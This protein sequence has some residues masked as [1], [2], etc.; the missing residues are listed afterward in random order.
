MYLE[1][2]EVENVR[3]IQTA[4]ISLTPRFNLFIGPNGSGKTSCLE[5]A[6]LLSTGKSFRSPRAR[7][8]ITHGSD[9]LRAGT[10]VCG[11][12]GRR[13]RIGVERSGSALRARVDGQE[14]RTAARLARELLVVVVEPD[15]QRLLTDGAEIRRRLLD[16]VMFHV[17]RDYSQ[18]HTR[19]RRA[20]KQRNAMLRNESPVDSAAW[21]T[22]VAEAG[23]AVA[24]IRDQHVPR[25]LEALSSIISE[26]V[27]R[28]I[29]LRF[30]HGFDTQTGLRAAL[31][32]AWSRDRSLGYT[33]SGPH[34]CDLRLETAG[35]SAHSVLS[36]GEGKL[37]AASLVVAQGLY[38]KARTGLTPV[39]LVDDLGAELDPRSRGR[40]FGALRD[41]QCQVL[42]TSV[43]PELLLEADPDHAK[44]FHVERGRVE[45]V[46]K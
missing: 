14:V 30:E 27:E 38:V 18:L 37:A 43:T 41:A 40:L 45:E 44:S 28:P 3:I 22:E 46:L 5:A 8:V 34:R 39:I 36:R 25:V 24:A 12:E 26:L 9:F 1:Q 10:V 7:D 35:E 19:Y 13:H 6:Y 11:E 16:W 23:E 33:S 2:L 17:E 32:Q 31:K 42:I 4:R 29:A 20:L 15:C 21:D